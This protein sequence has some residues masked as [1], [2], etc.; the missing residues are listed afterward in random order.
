MGHLG[1]E[2][3]ALLRLIL[4][5]L[6]G[7]MIGIERGMKG[8]AAGSRTFSLVCMGS[9][10]AMLTNEY[11]FTHLAGGTGDMTRMASQVISGIGFLGAG[12]IMMTS[13]NHVKGLTTAAALWGTAAIGIAIGCGFY[14]GGLAGMAAVMLSSNIYLQLDR[15]IV[16]RSRYMSIY[17]EGVNEEFMLHLVDCFHEAQIKVLNLT[18][19][20]KNQWYQKDIGAV[21]ELD[22]GKR[23]DHEEILERIREMED[24]RYVEE[25]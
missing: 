17:V 24:L 10:L 19:R 9:A 21:I 20:S 23:R 7:G 4:A 8:Q 18:R 11:V 5:S 22:L 12:T 25:V 6:C 2:G 16:A 1:F 14:L 3:A 15:K 13:H